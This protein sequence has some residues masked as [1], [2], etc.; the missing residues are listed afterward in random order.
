M[1]ELIEGR[2]IRRYKRFL[3][4]VRLSDGR[5]VTA[6]CPNTGSMKNCIEVN[7]L[8]WLSVADNPERKYKYTW[9]YIRTSRGHIIGVNT[10]FANRLVADAIDSGL[11]AELFGYEVMIREV[12]YGKEN[13]RVDFLLKGSNQIDCYLEVKSVTL[14][15]DPSIK[16]VG[17][18]PDSISVRSTKHLRELESIAL[19]GH[20]AV[21]FFCVQHTG[22]KEVRPADHIDSDYGEL[23]RK[24]QK[25]GVEI[26]AYKSRATSSGLKLWRSVPVNLK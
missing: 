6:H 1:R 26:L 23:L 11:V 13:S 5:L 21:L 15:E 14:L 22:V 2:L 10:N 3:A 9:E 20:R 25:S 8:V 4:D 18:F 24:V 17:Y 12:K 19:I 7:A 16:G